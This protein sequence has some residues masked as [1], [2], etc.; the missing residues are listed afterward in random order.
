M[1]FGT[2]VHETTN[3][4]IVEFTISQFFI[5]TN[6]LLEKLNEDN[7]YGF[8]AY[9]GSNSLANLKKKVAE[10]S[11]EYYSKMSG[12]IFHRSVDSMIDK[13]LQGHFIPC[14]EPTFDD[15]VPPDEE[16]A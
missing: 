14:Y 11:L 16:P 13:E 4:F 10:D 7:K 8:L 15:E 2:K 3:G 1:P 9:L 12:G 6:D 5:C